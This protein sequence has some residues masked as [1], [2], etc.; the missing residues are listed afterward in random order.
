[1]EKEKNCTSCGIRLIGKGVAY[2]PCPMCGEKE[3]GRCVTCRDQSVEYVCGS[4][5]F[6]G[7]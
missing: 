3:I 2:F 7:P 5:G 4:C 6:I 1:M